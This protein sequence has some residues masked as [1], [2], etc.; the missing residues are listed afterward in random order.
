M[1]DIVVTLPKKEGGFDHLHEKI[2]TI[3]NEEELAYW[4]MKRFP[5]KF[6]HPFE[7][8]FVCADGIVRG[9]FTID[10]VEYE[11]INEYDKP[12]IIWLKEWT[13]IKPIK[14]KGFRG[15]R[16]RKFKWENV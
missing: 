14:M 4:H 11:E 2:H 16:Y 15:F 13:P 12:Y 7:K 10:H 6:Q 8:M 3:E 1:T 5:K 9:F